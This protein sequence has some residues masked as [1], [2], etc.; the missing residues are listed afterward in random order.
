[1]IAHQHGGCKPNKWTFRA[2]KLS[3]CLII[4]FNAS[5]LVRQYRGRYAEVS[6]RPGDMYVFNANRL[7]RV[8][9]VNGP[10]ARI[11]LGA[12]INF[13]SDRKDVFVWA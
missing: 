10:L 1:M 12:F 9:P 4:L 8:S 6:L 2:S 13:D 5:L 11:T 3:V 7:H